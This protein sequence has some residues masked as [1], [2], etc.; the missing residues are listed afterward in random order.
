[1]GGKRVEKWWAGGGGGQVGELQN[2]WGDVVMSLSPLLLVVPENMAFLL[3]MAL[4]EQKGG[5]A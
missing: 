1:M 5:G 4:P 2:K 3:L